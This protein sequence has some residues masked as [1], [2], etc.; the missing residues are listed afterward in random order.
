MATSKE[1]APSGEQSIEKLQERFQ[2]LNKRKIQAE[3]NLEHARTQLET[4][5]AEARE[6]YGTDDLAALREKLAQMKAENEAK[7]ASYQEQLDK[8]EA[9][10]ASVEHKFAAESSPSSN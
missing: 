10:L 2:Q 7:R 1:V 9:D 5:Q 3:T 6:K 8:I 4:L